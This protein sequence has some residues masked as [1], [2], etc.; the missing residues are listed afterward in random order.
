MRTLIKAINGGKPFLVDYQIA[1]Q[2]LQAKK[3][4]GLSD[5]I[6]QIFGEKPKPYMVGSTYVIPVQG[7]IGKGLSPLDAIGSVDVDELDDQI[8]AAVAAN[9]ARI[10]FHINSDGGTIDGVE[11]VAEKIRSLP[12]DTIS[13][14]AGSMNSAALW[15]IAL[16]L[17]S[18]SRLRL[19]ALRLRFIR[20]AAAPLRVWVLPGQA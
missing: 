17:I 2:Y 3:S 8:D 1:E 15:C 16:S 13:F 20:I 5:L 14:T 12:M 4:A 6:S 18:V 19:W 10:L 7:M 11:E 9:P